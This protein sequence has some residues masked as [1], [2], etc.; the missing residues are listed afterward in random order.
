MTIAMAYYIYCEI[1]M[2]LI[3]TFHL[4][5]FHYDDYFFLFSFFFVCFFSGT[6]GVANKPV[7]TRYQYVL[8]VGQINSFAR[9]I[10]LSSLGF[11]V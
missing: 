1:Q 10:I 4:F 3:F 6:G 11:E 5:N 9:K 2:S 7:G 8:C